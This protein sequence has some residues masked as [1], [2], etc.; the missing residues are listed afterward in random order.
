MEKETVQDDFYKSGPEP[1]SARPK[2][3]RRRRSSS[4]GV[5]DEHKKRRRR[6][7]NRGLSRIWHQFR[8][9][10][11]FRMKILWVLAIIVVV[12]V[13]VYALA[14]H[15]KWQRIDRLPPNERSAVMSELMQK[16]RQK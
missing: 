3:K 7:K 1:T 9:H 4:D 2:R 6:S 13:L 15:L 11:D 16:N 8:R 5:F 10:A 14:E 12:G